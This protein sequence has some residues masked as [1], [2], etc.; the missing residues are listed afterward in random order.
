M[1]K[2]STSIY[3]SG[4]I[5]LIKPSEIVMFLQQIYLK[6]F[7]IV[8]FSCFMPPLTKGFVLG[9]PKTTSMLGD[10][11]KKTHRTQHIVAHMAKIYHDERIQSKI[12]EGSKDNGAW[13]ESGE[14][15][16]QASKSPLPVEAL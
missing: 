7:V 5:V 16:A 12:S 1:S 10:L 8:F 3:S 9:I 11:L 6:V 2:I 13:A 14:N 4:R 15:Q